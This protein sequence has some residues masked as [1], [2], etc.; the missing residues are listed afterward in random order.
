[1]SRPT[2]EA[3]ASIRRTRQIPAGGRLCA[4]GGLACCLFILR[5][6][7]A[8]WLVR[9]EAGR[10]QRLRPVEPSEIIGLTET[11]GGL[12]YEGEVEAIT[13]C[14]IDS[15]PQPDFQALL[16]KDPQL[17]FRL[18]RLLGTNLQKSILLARV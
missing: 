1:L 8:Q 7:R 6:G 15:I 3:L 2:I 13:P 12:P 14:E 16:E 18:V 9:D 10:R 17:S 11:L 5:E 4:E